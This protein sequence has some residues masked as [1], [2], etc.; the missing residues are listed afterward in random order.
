M[1]PCAR[2]AWPSRFDVA[3]IELLWKTV[4]LQ[5]SLGTPFGIMPAVIGERKLL[6][7]LSALPEGTD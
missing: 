1:G 6:L 4:S 5:R 7:G 2:T 3:Y